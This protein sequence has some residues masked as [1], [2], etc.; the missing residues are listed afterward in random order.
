MLHDVWYIGVPGNISAV[1]PE[2]L[3]WI[4]VQFR[5]IIRLWD[6]GGERLQMREFG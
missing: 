4:I 3:A 6:S 2:S 5:T 1:E